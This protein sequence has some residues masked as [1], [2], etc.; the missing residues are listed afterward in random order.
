VNSEQPGASGR[1]GVAP[2]VDL[3]LLADYVGGAL[4]GT[5]E[6]ARTAALVDSD[7]SWSTTLERLRTAETLVRADLARL[8]EAPEPVPTDIAT[9]L[10][11][12][13]TNAASPESADLPD[14]DRKE[15]VSLRRARARRR[16]R[17]AAVAAVAAGL[18]ALVVPAGSMLPGTDEAA[19]Q[20][21]TADRADE[22]SGPRQ[23]PPEATTEGDPRTPGPAALGRGY[24]VPVAASGTDY[25][26]ATLSAV[27]GQHDMAAGDA[28]PQVPGALSRLKALPALDDCLT[29]IR[30][31]YPGT[32]TIV[33]YARFEG[34]PALIV[35]IT[36]VAGRNRVVVAGPDCG[37]PGVDERYT[38]TG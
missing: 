17:I 6:Q 18:L 37:H 5:P 7:P 23:Q 31:V 4:E 32:V 27:R 29:V 2:G 35:A 9:R 25:S 12:A 28:S 21:T 10:E 3:D 19:E 22:G 11:R 14:T 30:S 38:A 16:Y 34:A 24:P 20:G 26:R 15:P 1:R 13:L 36:E 33:D 8:A